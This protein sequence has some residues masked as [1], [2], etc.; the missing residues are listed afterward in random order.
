VP[1]GLIGQMLF[2]FRRSGAA[3]APIASSDTLPASAGRPQAE[4][5]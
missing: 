3:A 2:P 5:S 1:T 4:L